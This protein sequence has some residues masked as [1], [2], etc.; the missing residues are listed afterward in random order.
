ME[1]EKIERWR[2]ARSLRATSLN[3]FGTARLLTHI[4]AHFSVPDGG[5]RPTDPRWTRRRVV[6]LSP[7]TL[8][9]LDD[10]ASTF[11]RSGG[12]RVEAMQ[13]AALLLETIT[14]L[15]DPNEIER[16]LR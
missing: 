15:L 12:V 5:G 14:K 8:R 11:R 3:P 1:D 6:P 4:Q 7:E 9:R 16:D 2:M 10:V 13:L